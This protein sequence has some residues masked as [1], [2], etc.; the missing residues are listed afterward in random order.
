MIKKF[1]I[2]C[3]K[4][5][6]LFRKLEGDIP[7]PM[8]VFH[9][10][11]RRAVSEI[12]ATL[13]LVVVT[14]VGAVMVSSFFQ[15]SH[16]ADIGSQFNSNTLQAQTPSSI[17]L[18]GYD[19][20]DRAG[21]SGINSTK[22]G[23]DLDNFYDLKLCT[24]S[25]ISSANNLPTQSPKGT[26][27]MIL[28]IKNFGSSPV[29]ISDILV[30]DIDHYWDSSSTATGNLAISVGGKYPQA[31]KFVIIP[32]SNSNPISIIST[33]VVQ[34][35]GEVRLLIKLSQNVVMN[36]NSPTDLSLNVPIK[37]SIHAGTSNPPTFTILSG[38]VM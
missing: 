6:A 5:N 31:G 36:S 34:G 16:M 15:G 28:G 22:T 27:F 10:R 21:L 25:C 17:Q 3:I 11:N 9:G 35:G 13:L 24:Q 30:N 29:T 7:S 23:T 19:T 18:T 1:N 33:N 4:K 12:I 38:D 14:V 32:V 37:I 8:K 20:R 2:V 26:D